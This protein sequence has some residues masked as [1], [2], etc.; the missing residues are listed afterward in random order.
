M[1]RVDG[2]DRGGTDLEQRLV[3]L[4][5]ALQLADVVVDDEIPGGVG[6][7]DHRHDD[8]LD[9]SKRAVPAGSSSDG[10]ETSRSEGLVVA[11]GLAAQV[12]SDDQVIEVAPYRLVPRIAEELLGS[13]VPRRDDPVAVDRDDGCRVDLDE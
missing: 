7:L 11:H 1:L 4:L 5:L 10:M 13:Q 12:L 6:P 8:Q 9:V 2:D 3:V